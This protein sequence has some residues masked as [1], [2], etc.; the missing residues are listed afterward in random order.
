MDRHI[1]VK[2]IYPKYRLDD[3]CFRIGA[4]AGVT[5][6]ISD[7]YGELWTLVNALDGARPLGEVVAVVR[8][9]FPHLGLDDVLD[10]VRDLD[11][12]GFVEDAEPTAYD[13]D[14]LSRYVGNI[15]YF[16]HYDRLSSHRGAV[17]D[18]LRAAHCVLFGLGGGGSYILPL[19]LGA[20]F[21][22]ITAVDY[23]RVERTNLNR[24]FLYRESDLGSYKSEAAARLAGQL[25]PDVAFVPVQ[26]RIESATQAAELVRGADVAI[27]AIDEPPFI[28]QRRVNAGCVRE[29]V[30]YV[31]G[32][33]FVTRGR[34]FTVR[35]FET[36]CLDCLHLYYRR[37]DPRYLTKLGAALRSGLGSVTIA[38][39][40]HIALVA[41]MI[42]G[43]AI[44]LVTGHA[45]PIALARQID[46]HF[47]T[48]AL[49]VMSSWP[50][51]EIGCP[52]CGAGADAGE[53]EVWRAG[54]SSPEGFDE[55]ALERET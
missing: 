39:P 37:N 6:E 38:F 1:R 2:P 17:Q 4:Q 26:Q 20:G 16:S 54:V 10:A 19:L 47:E 27:C 8:E 29:S 14:D 49:Q 11:G 52:V 13:G 42:A 15:N 33:S 40:P 48:G 35:P 41:A 22:K 45:E 32:G 23:D 5:V 50:R 36:G 46:V 44:R 24:Q 25:N 31:G 9:A 43:E 7:P 12:R 34:M 51:D 53:F 3:G 55:L 28:A 30:P 21:G 18:R